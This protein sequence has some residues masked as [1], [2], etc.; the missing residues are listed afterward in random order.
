M[1]RKLHRLLAV[2]VSVGVIGCTSEAPKPAGSAGGSKAGPAIAVVKPERRAIKRVVEQPGS[3]QAYEETELFARIPGYVRLICEDPA[4]K[5]RPERC[6][7]IGSRVKAGQVLAELA[8]PEL[9]EETK[10]KDALV[11]QSAAEIEQAKKS[12]AATEAA[13]ATAQ[14]LVVEAKAGLSRAQA[15]YDRWHSELTRI[16]G[17]VKGGV[18]DAQTRDE[19]QNQFLAAEATRNEAAAKVTSAEAGVTKARADRDKSEADVVAAGA[20]LDVARAEV[21]RMTALLGY[22]KLV[23]PYDG[24]VTRRAV[25][26]GDFV[27]GDGKKQGVFTVARLDPVRIVVRVPE[28]EAELVREGLAVRIAVQALGG[29]E[30]TGTVARTSWSLEPGSR[31]LRTEIDLPNPDGRVRPGMYV[32]A[33]LTAELPP[34]WT[35]PAAAVGRAGDESVVY[36]VEDGK[37]VRSAVQVLRGDGQ[38][39]QVRRYKKPGADWIDFNGSESVATP[40]AALSDGQ[41]ITAAPPVR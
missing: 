29:P 19:T 20:R 33:R 17:L 37:A 11:R 30:L 15:L 12:L 38:V 4:R 39:T 24:V 10:Q 35:V 21:G 8:V 32:Y 40:A 28:A 25:D 31:T 14:A 27:G 1:I 7:D 2:V 13:V 3:V 18:I 6:I 23:A 34:A 22:S 36:L 5:G 16:S 9:V 26:T 41:A